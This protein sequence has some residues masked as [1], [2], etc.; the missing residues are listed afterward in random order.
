MPG[1]SDW[2]LTRPG[3][4][5]ERLSAAIA[6]VTGQTPEKT[7]GGGTSDA[8]F[9]KDVCPVV[10]FGLVG[11][12][13]HQV[14]ERVPIADLRAAHRHLP[15][16]PRPHLRGGGAVITLNEIA[17]SLQGAWLLFLD[18]GNAMRLFDAS[19]GGFWRS[20]QAIILVAPAYEVTVLADRHALL[21]GAG[22]DTFN[23]VAYVAARWLAFAFDWITLP[24]LLA[25]LAG[26][27]D[28]R[29]GY[30][31]YVVARNWS[32]V[33]AVLPFAVIALVDL[34]GL[35]SPDILFFPL[36]WRWRS[37]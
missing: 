10:E 29:R 2:F 25:A 22:S 8:R 34:T 16:L 13:M 19:Y 30:P 1:A 14:D 21:A 35:V 31:A 28:I 4:L 37:R 17:R 36:C 23:E 15:P 12:T 5:V 24:L 3:A 27:L 20:F 26:F 33:L 11:D 9:F 18:R 6:D 32:S 7:T